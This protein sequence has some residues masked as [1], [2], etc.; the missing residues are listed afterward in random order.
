MLIEPYSEFKPVSKC[1][2]GTL[3]R[4]A[5]GAV[6]FVSK[7]PPNYS[8]GNCLIKMS[9]A[10]QGLLVRPAVHLTPPAE[11]VVVYACQD[12]VLTAGTNFTITEYPTLGSVTLIGSEWALFLPMP[13]GAP[14]FFVLG[15][16][17]LKLR[18]EVER[19]SFNSWKLGLAVPQGEAPPKLVPLVEWKAPEGA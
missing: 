12:F 6:A 1:D 14:H 17:E 5:R 3:V 11:K 19:A 8:G 16:W 4:D 15:T 2:P 13:N 7:P 9:P 18:E 10:E